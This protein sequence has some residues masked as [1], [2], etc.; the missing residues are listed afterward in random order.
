MKILIRW[1]RFTQSLPDWISGWQTTVLESYEV[2]KN[3]RLLKQPLLGICH[4]I[5]PFSIVCCV[6]SLPFVSCLALPCLW[7]CVLSAWLGDIPPVS[8]PPFPI[9]LHMP[10]TEK[11]GSTWSTSIYSLVT[12]PAFLKSS[13]FSPWT[14]SR[15]IS[16]KPY[17]WSP[18]FVSA[19]QL[20]VERL[21]VW[22]WSA[23][24]TC[25]SLSLTLWL[26]SD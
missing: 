23:I 17:T 20:P 2:I 13:V 14:I 7:V 4:L 9:H 18:A 5:P 24:C 15:L 1:P 26:L 11:K 12:P 10:I 3:Y 6:F 19:L 22:C 8:S 21:P 25:S 16:P